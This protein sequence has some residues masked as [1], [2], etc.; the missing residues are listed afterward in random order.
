ML[1]SAAK[2]YNTVNLSACR[3][4]LLAFVLEVNQGLGLREK[5]LELLHCWNSRVTQIGLASDR[6]RFAP[7]P[8][9][10]AGVPWWQMRV[11]ATSVLLDVCICKSRSLDYIAGYVDWAVDFGFLCLFEQVAGGSVDDCC[12]W[13][14]VTEV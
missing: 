1:C 14:Q 10:H 5:A 9:L 12:T 8:D 3:K 13:L 11:R 6:G 4:H 7:D 2:I